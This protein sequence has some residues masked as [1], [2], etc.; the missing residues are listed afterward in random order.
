MSP[1][2][3]GARIA[4]VGALTTLAALIPAGSASAVTLAGEWA[5]FTRC[6]V[7]APAMLAADG[8]TTAPLCLASNSP[9]GSIK[10]GS[11][12]ATTGNSDLQFGLISA[13]SAGTAALVSPSGGAIIADPAPVPG[14]LLGLMCPSGV[15]LVSEVCRLA[16]DND[17]NNVT[18]TVQQ[19]G[20]LSDFDLAAALAVGRPIL[21]LPVKIHLQNPLLGPD[22]FIG[23]EADPIVLRPKNLAAPTG[24]FTRF[25]GDG[26]RNPTG[27]VMLKIGLSGA[28]Q[29]DDSFAVPGATG[30][31]VLGLLSPAIDLKT[32]LPSPAGDNNLVL[33]D[34]TTFQ[35]G[36]NT[37]RSFAPDAGQQL[38]AFWHSAVTS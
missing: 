16:T 26:T 35:G 31:G 20:A 14:G 36:L 23:S 2:R 28:S 1:A 13:G 27:G 3:K 5:P 17:L 21:T 9:S 38:S 29:G 11:T 32:G 22:C 25:D 30:C 37:P 15:P 7:D 18:A 24:S 4:M 19:A 34:A 6:P 33:D 12:T 10:L 8:A